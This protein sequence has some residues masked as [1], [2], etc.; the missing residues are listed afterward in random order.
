VGLIAR[1]LEEAG[2]A[3]TLTSWNAGRTRVTRPPRA[4]FTKL[5]RG[6]SMGAPGDA[7]QQMRILRATLD[8][9]SQPAPQNPVQLDE[10]MD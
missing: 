10:S 8:L 4:T 5:K 3:T 9:L 2:I 7:A 6:A 1:G